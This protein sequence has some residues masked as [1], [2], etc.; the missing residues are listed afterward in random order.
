MVMLCLVCDLFDTKEGRKF[1]LQAKQLLL[2][3]ERLL[4]HGVR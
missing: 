1:S 3:Y 2:S 4:L